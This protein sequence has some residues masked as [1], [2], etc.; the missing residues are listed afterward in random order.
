MLFAGALLRCGRIAEAQQALEDARLVA[1]DTGRHAYD[2]EQF[3]LSGVIHSRLGQTE[4]AEQAFR[5]AITI[6]PAQRARWL[7][8][9]AARAYADF[10]LAWQKPEEA[11]RILEPVWL[12]IEEGRTTTDYLFAEALLRSLD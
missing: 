1:G 9:R 10:L 7:E 3:R 5:Q 2:A 8:L 11:R 6:A 4:A 12:A